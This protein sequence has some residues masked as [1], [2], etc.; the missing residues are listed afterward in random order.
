MP[1]A[2]AESSFMLSIHFADT[3]NLV[4]FNMHDVELRKWLKQSESLCHF[5][6]GKILKNVVIKMEKQEDTNEKLKSY[7]LIDYLTHYFKPRDVVRKRTKFL[8]F[9]A[10]DEQFVKVIRN[11]NKNYPRR[12]KSVNGSQVGEESFSMKGIV[13]KEENKTKFNYV[14]VRLFIIITYYK[15]LFE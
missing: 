2:S 3:E 9:D 12:K 4:F 7:G 10:K 8:M 13:V 15:F 11:R 6:R 14:E 1:L 5:E